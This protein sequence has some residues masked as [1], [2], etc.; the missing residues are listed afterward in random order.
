MSS[1]SVFTLGSLSRSRADMPTVLISSAYASFRM[2]CSAF[3]IE[4]RCLVSTVLSSW[5]ISSIGSPGWASSVRIFQT[6]LSRSMRAALAAAARRSSSASSSASAASRKRRVSRSLHALAQRLHR[7]GQPLRTACRAAPSPPS[8]SSLLETPRARART[9]DR[10]NGRSRTRGP[11]GAQQC[12]E[13]RPGAHK[14]TRARTHARVRT[15]GFTKF[16]NAPAPPRA[17]ARSPARARQRRASSRSLR[18]PTTWN[19]LITSKPSAHSGDD[20][21]PVARREPPTT[22]TSHSGCPATAARGYRRHDEERRD[23]EL[24]RA[25]PVRAAVGRRVPRADVPSRTAAESVMP[26]VNH[27]AHGPAT[28]RAAR[29]RRR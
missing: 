9:L 11:R 15:M 18:R 5:V 14:R 25:V 26:I 4:D 8:S 28:P 19:T 10:G 7:V 1:M 13:R 24:G 22:R 29:S 3:V 21:P 2:Q 23:E 20:V 6:F 17:P 27:V 16:R 12:P